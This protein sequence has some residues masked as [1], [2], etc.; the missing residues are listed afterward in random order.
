MF[1]VL[2]LQ[3]SYR[4][5][6]KQTEEQTEEESGMQTLKNK[7]E[8]RQICKSELTLVTTARVTINLNDLNVH[9][10]FDLAVM[11]S[12]MNMTFY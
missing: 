9:I 2:A 7:H 12:I 10:N 6:E 4:Q 5:T 8:I 3:V 1:V 11:N